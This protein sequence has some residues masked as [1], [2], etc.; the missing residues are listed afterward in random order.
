MRL[1]LDI[2]TNSIGWWLY[3]ANLNETIDGG[4]R[5]FSDGRDP[6][7][8]ASLAVDRRVARAMRRRRDRYLRRRTVLMERLAAAGLMPNDPAARKA[9]EGL[10]P[11]ALRA[12]GLSHRLSLNEL[13]RALF[14]LNQRRGF[15]S[16]RKTDRGS[17]EKESG[18]VASGVDRLETAI[19]ES[20]TKTLGQYLHQRRQTE[21]IHHTPPVRTRMTTL[22]IGDK[23]EDGYDFYPSRALLEDEFH[24]IWHEQEKHHPALTEALRDT[25]FETIFYQRPL[26]APVIGRCLFEDEPRL[27]KAHPLF[28][29]RI[30][31]E[32]VNALRVR[33]PGQPD[34]G[35]SMEE[36]NALI[37]LF[38]SKTAK[39]P[40]TANQS[41]TQIR[42]TLRLRPDQSLTHEGKTRKGIECD[43]LRA[44]LAHP[45]R[46][47]ATWG[48][49]TIDEQWELVQKLRDTEDA[50]A[51]EQWLQARFDIDEAQAMHIANTPVPEGYGRIG[52]QATSQILEHLIAEVI[53]F[54]VAAEMVYGDHRGIATGE[55]ID[56]LP[57]YGEILDKH[58]IPGSGAPEDDD[59][60]RFGRITNPTV[61]IGLNQLR[62][63]VN[64][65]IDVYGKPDEIIVEL[66]R[67]LKNSK[68][69]KIEI[70]KAIKKNTDAA[71]QRGKKLE[72]IGER[73]NGENRLRLRL[74]EEL[75]D[76]CMDR[77][78][79]YTG[80]KISVAMLFDGS[81]DID[82]IL[83]YSRTLDDSIANRTLCM[84]EANRQKGNQTPWEI[85]GDRP[86]WDDIA[87]L[88]KRLPKNKQWRFAPDAMERFEGENDFLA[89]QLVDTQY[90]SR[91]AREYL[92]RLY[93]EE[94]QTGGKIH[95]YVTPGRLTEMLRRVWGLNNLLGEHNLAK[96]KNR[97]DH[98]HHAIDAA[99]IGMTDRTLLN[100]ISK[101][102]R[103]AEDVRA[104]AEKIEPPWPGFRADLTNQLEKITVSHRA[105]HGRIN[106]ETR[107]NGRDSTAGQLHNDTAYGPTD[108]ENV[109]VTRKPLLTIK[110]A[111][112][113]RIRDK[114][115]QARLYQQTEGLDGKDF[116][117]A[118]EA[119]SKEDT[120]YRG[121]RRLRLTEKL[122]TIP[123]KDNKG[124]IYKGY[125]GDS[126]HSY[127][128]WRL[129]DQKF[130]AQVLTT[131]DAHQAETIARPHPAAKRIMKL[132]Q[133][134]MVEIN[135]PEQGKI[136]VRVVKFGQSGS[137]V[138][139]K[140]TEAGALKARH[141][142]EGDAFRYI[143]SGAN[144]LMKMGVRRV[145]V[146]ELGKVEYLDSPT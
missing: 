48:R 90:L 139:A 143:N 39:N 71:I 82:H 9:L 13:G 99:V 46:L 16:N 124:R 67:D 98:R 131:F 64:K 87:P 74:W 45:D 63:L 58:V 29:R 27:A 81:C 116:I 53:P 136:I 38:D 5:I 121:I 115:L 52:L 14:H 79:P 76:D 19:R 86:Q 51:L 30:L 108:I 122:K 72:E 130:T 123:I 92:S 77:R 24:K 102:H 95:V 65:I 36:R 70:N 96:P 1:G 6:K 137:I 68:D 110:P 35:L 23:S 113:S 57:Y 44:L 85:W 4:V 43:R 75:N 54:S 103:Q 109:V 112:I 111:D 129:P 18:K 94:K 100:R 118:L 144:P 84:R 61:H 138:F 83:P 97:H 134:D 11:Y 141:A 32:T 2:G 12:K 101:L 119:F 120:P 34:R 80:T 126:N 73:N 56:R 93:P 69:Q 22:T 107:K 128:I 10:D 127:E 142:D 8:K 146:S 114:H 41:F 91:I 88:I 60:T 21:T 140:H 3:A 37:L 49:M 132:F 89:R 17:N 50:K 40:G 145:Y 15:K 26:K 59:I 135:H 33:E 104:A 117:A 31:F 7:S 133:N 78:C 55:M 66:A 105:D 42:K 20:G 106:F 125:K 25:L 28:Q 47:G 62:R